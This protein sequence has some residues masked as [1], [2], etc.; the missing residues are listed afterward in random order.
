MLSPDASKNRHESKGFLM[1]TLFLKTELLPALCP[2]LPGLIVGTVAAVLSKLA[3]IGA[4]WS[5]VQ[6]IAD[7]TLDWVILALGLWAGGA[8]I[9]S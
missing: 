6:F 7:L 2:A 5:L 4:L 9:A 1:F 8:V 3:M